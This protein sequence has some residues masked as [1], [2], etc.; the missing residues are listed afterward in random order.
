MP[1]IIHWPD[2]D[3]PKGTV[4]DIP[5]HIIDL[6]PTM[7]SAAKADY[8]QNY[9]GL[10]TMPLP[11]VSLLN[12]WQDGKVDERLRKRALFFEHQ[13]SRAVREGNWKLVA[14]RGEPW[15]LYNMKDDRTESDNLVKRHPIIAKY[16]AAKWDLW[17]EKNQVTPLPKNLGADYLV[18]LK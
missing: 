16:L 10:P 7:L 17:A 14:T 13:G 9:Q 5:A 1:A 2:A 11:G 12:L 3:L 4:V 6:V 18:P 8:P 15:E